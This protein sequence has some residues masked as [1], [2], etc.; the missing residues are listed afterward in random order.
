[1]DC[2]TA[3]LACG[4]ESGFDFDFS[5]AFNNNNFSNQ[6]LKIKIIPNLFE[7]KS[8][9]KGCTSIVILAIGNKN[10]Q[11]EETKKEAGKRVEGEGEKGREKRIKKWK[12]KRKYNK[13]TLTFAIVNC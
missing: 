3:G 8:N 2:S 5:F 7:G 11:R 12:G 9:D 13:I 4:S 10:R 1:L 6:V